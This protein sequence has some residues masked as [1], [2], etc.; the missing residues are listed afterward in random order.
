MNH[1]WMIAGAA[2]LV[3]ICRASGFV[4]NLKADSHIGEQ[5]LHFMPI[6]IFST[7]VLSSIM[8]QTEVFNFELVALIFA[9]VIVWR[10]RQFGWAVIAGLGALWLLVQV[11]PIN[12]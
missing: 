11:I 6:A 10:T 4:P 5:F 12:H 3:Y 1:F 9:G 2:V 7:L 8:R